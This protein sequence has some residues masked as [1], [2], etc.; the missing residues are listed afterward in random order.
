MF[1][2]FFFLVE[3]F[4]VRDDPL[5]P[6]WA[7]SRAEEEEEECWRWFRDPVPELQIA[8]AGG[9]PLGVKA[10]G[11][12]GVKGEVEPEHKKKH[13]VGKLNEMLKGRSKEGS[14]GN[15]RKI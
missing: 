4:G 12:Q 3:P 14:R 13:S 9:G 8:D 7:A 10:P 6:R 5:G 11:G 15:T 1:E 2:V